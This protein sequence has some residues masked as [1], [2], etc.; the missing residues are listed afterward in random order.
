MFTYMF[1]HIYIH[2][3]VVITSEINHV[4]QRKLPNPIL[5]IIL[6]GYHI[7]IAFLHIWLPL[8][9]NNNIILCDK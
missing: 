5:S 6:L 7:D 3:L 8:V 2:M 1:L 9:S 4:V